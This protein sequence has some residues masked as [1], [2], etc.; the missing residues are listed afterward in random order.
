MPQ[1]NDTHRSRRSV[2]DSTRAFQRKLYC[3]AK[4]NGKRRFH[5]LYDKVHR[6]DFLWRAWS[7][8]A[9]KG[10]APG[11]DGVTIE[12]VKEAGADTLLSELQRELAEGSY[13]PLPVRRVTIPKRSGGE[14]HLGVPA[15]RDRIVQASAKLVL[16]PIF[17]A[18]FADCSFGFRPKR[19]ALQARE[20][21]RSGLRRGQR[22]VVDAD[23]KSFFDELDQKRLLG[24]VRE[25]VSDRRIVELLHGWLRSGVL[26]GGNVLHPKAGTPQ[27]GVISPL[28]ANA[29][30]HRLDQAWQARGRR[31]GELTRYADDLVAMCG[32]AGRAETALGELRR[33]L[34]ELGLELSKTKTRIVDC[35]TGSEGFDFLGYHFRMRPTRRNRNRLF[36]ACWPSQMAVAAA[37]NRVRELT[38]LARIGKPTIMV[39]ED[40]NAFLRGW[41]AYF[42]H[43]NSTQQFKHLD[44]YVQHRVACFIAR[45]HGSRTWR[46]GLVDLIDSHTGLGLLRLAGT[47]SYSTA[48]AAR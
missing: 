8:V 34:A 44:G 24:F 6:R 45:K 15:V 14:R 1:A 26:V 47:V 41:G 2:L 22:W 40:L 35:R 37:K 27:G 32:S 42:R 17:E 4:Q 30:L 46:R 43:G 36:A 31:F 5:A 16:E 25:R 9:R 10:G 48:Q 21:I 7:E 3:A 19:S 39:V 12:A 23:I 13:R 33:L 38:P 28:L 11:V 18:D 20:R 29:Y